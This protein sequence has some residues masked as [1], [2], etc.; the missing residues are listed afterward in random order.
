M[1]PGRVAGL[2]AVILLLSGTIAYELTSRDVPP[3]SLSAPPGHRA[4][5]PEMNTPATLRH[6]GI[7]ARLREVLARPLFN[8][9]RKPVG[10]GTRNVIGLPRLTGIIVTGSRKVAI[11]AAPAGGKPVVVEEGAHI[12]DYE[13][14]EISDTTVTVAGPAGTTVMTPLFD[15]APSP[16]R[17]RPPPPPAQSQKK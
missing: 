7:D 9:D 16:V 15:A 14:K 11:F 5:P 8:P 12:N 13:L 4:S 10:T 3:A 17:Q 1:I 2:S 6:S